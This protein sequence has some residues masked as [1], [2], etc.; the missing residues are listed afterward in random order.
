MDF[1]QAPNEEGVQT[2]TIEEKY[3]HPKYDNPD[4]YN[5][6]LVAILSVE[7]GL[8]LKYLHF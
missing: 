2:I 6:S 5:E 7:N 1:R 4:R 8:R 3:M